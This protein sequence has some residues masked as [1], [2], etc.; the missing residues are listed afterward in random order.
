MA[1]IASEKQATDIIVTD[2]RGISSITDYQVVLSADNTRL[3][4]AILDEVTEKLKKEGQ[5]PLHSEGIGPDQ[6]WLIVDYGP[7]MM[8]V[9]TPE[10]RTLFDFD[11]LWPA[12]KTVLALQ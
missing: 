10:K 9:F 11:R 5:R 1:D 12:A 2:V 6:D 8:H 7:V 3:A 4:R